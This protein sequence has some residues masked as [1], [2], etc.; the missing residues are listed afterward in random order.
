MPTPQPKL[1]FVVNVDW[2]FLSHRLPIALEAMRQGYEVHIAVG[3]T[4]RL[5]EMQSHGLRVHPLGISRS[6]TGLGEALK[7]ARQ[8]WSVYKTVQPDVVHLVTIKPVLMGGIL[9]RPAGVPAVVAAV[10]GL[11]FVFLET[12]LVAAL[13]RKLVGVLYQASFGHRNLKVIFQNAQDKATLVQLANLPETKTELIRGSGVDISQFT[14]SP[15]PSGM[16]VVML[17]ARL[18]ADKGV[19]EF[20]QA[21]RLLKTG[22]STARFCLVGTADLHNPTSL[23]QTELDAYQKEGIVELWGHR[24]DMAAT[25]STAHIVVL[26]SY[27]EGL[28]KVLIEA[29]ACGRAVVTTDVPGCRDAI[30]PGVTGVLVPARNAHALSQAIAALLRDP[31]RCHAMGQAGR[32]LAEQA[33]DI[34]QVVAQHLRIYAGLI[35]SSKVRKA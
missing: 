15:L 20:V 17:A 10:S 19:R 12:G 9:A 23:T 29:A 14:A 30:E 8:I 11:G 28:P 2:F 25:L 34:Q 35:A 24:T 5:A 6:K 13:R 4:D 21:A 27:R 18:L 22:G 33:F 26:P 1:L 32:A 3:I 7:V 31:E 16:P